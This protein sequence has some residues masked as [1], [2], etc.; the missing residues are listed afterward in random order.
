MS[1]Y[2]IQVCTCANC[3]FENNCKFIDYIKES[4]N[5]KSINGFYYGSSTRLSENGNVYLSEQN[6]FIQKTLR[7]KNEL[8]EIILTKYI[9]EDKIKLAISNISIHF[10]S[11]VL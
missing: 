4:L 6:K 5:K 11:G 8:D 9:T 3:L 2:T 10:K 1:I 7:I